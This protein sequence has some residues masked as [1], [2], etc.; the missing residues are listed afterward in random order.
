MHNT[1][2]PSSAL[3]EWA[4]HLFSL[5]YRTCVYAVF[6]SSTK[7]RLFRFEPSGTIA[8][9]LW[10]YEI[11]PWPLVQFFLRFGQGDGILRGFDH[12]VH[13][14]TRQEDALGRRMLAG[15]AQVNGK[16]ASDEEKS[17]RPVVKIRVPKRIRDGSFRDVLA[18]FHIAA[19]GLEVILFSCFGHPLFSHVSGRGNAL[20]SRPYS[21]CSPVKSCA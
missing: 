20:A 1:L 2:D 3:W 21:T 13:P 17:R 14:A 12:T 15:W 9:R 4:D 11:D 16:Q 5:Q 6:I 8:T 7:A 10:D 19:P 18:W